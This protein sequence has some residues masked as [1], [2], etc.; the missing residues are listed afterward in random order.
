[1]KT[2]SAVSTVSKTSCD[3]YEYKTRVKN[4]LKK[5]RDSK[6]EGVKYS[7]NQYKYHTKQRL[8]LKK[9]KEPKHGGVIKYI[10]V[11][12]VSIKY[13]AKIS[14]VITKYPNMKV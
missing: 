3:H 1:M 6:H 5:H 11:T 14:L 10:H 13:L 2:V 4:N 8:C 12:H 9:H 7:C